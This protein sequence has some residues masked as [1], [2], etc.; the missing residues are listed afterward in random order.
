MVK[1]IQ[2]VRIT[3]LG[4]ENNRREIKSQKLNIKNTNQNLKFEI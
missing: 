2:G 4:E 3:P 1:F